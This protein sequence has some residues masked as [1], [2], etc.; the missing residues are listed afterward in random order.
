[1]VILFG[2]ESPPSITSIDLLRINL[3]KLQTPQLL[4]IMEQLMKRFANF[5]KG[6]T[7]KQKLYEYSI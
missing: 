2:A 6:P 5:G 4:L 3:I 7:I 1:M